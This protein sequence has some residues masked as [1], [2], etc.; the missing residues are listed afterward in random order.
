[1]ITAIEIFPCSGGLSEGFRRAG[2]EFSMSF[3]VDCDACASHERNLGTRPIQIDVRELLRMIRAGWS[4][5]PLDLLVADPPCTPWSRAGK[6]KGLADARDMLSE[7]VELIA[8]LRPRAALIGNIPGLDDAPHLAVVQRT[9]GSLARHGYCAAD[10]ARLDAADFGVPQRRVRP[11]WFAHRGGPCIRWPARTHAPAQ[12]L[13]PSLPGLGDLL[14]WVTCRDALAHLPLE[15]LGRPVRLRKRACKT[16]QHGS[17]PG[18]PAR[19]VGTSNVSDGNVLLLNQRHPISEPDAPARAIKTN[20]GR[21]AQGGS[22]LRLT[23]PEDLRPKR[24]P[25]TRTQQS[26]AVVLSE[27]AA[28]ILQGFPPDWHFA[29]SSKRSRWEQIG[30]AVPPPVAHAIARSVAAQFA[31]WRAERGEAA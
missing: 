23:P 15:E 18:R 11:F 25:S 17:I 20:G 14:P 21:A 5:G 24:D 29:G 4:P 9:I 30:Q 26:D 13:Q 27:R 10:F 2:I 3:D 28:A 7:T 31:T 6:R 19:T 8:L 12:D 16:K 1:L 22:T